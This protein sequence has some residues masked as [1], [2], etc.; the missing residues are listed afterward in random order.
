DM[1]ALRNKI[2][3]RQYKAQRATLEARMEGYTQTIERT[4]AIFRGA[5]GAY[6]DYVKQLDL[7]EADLTDAQ[8]TLNTLEARQSRG[9]ISM[10]TYKKNIAD[11]QKT[12]DRA[13]SIMNGTLL[14]LREKIR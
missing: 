11:A 10:E 4:K 8:E 2:P 5:S 12:R 1:K 6:P 13:E 3:R 7:A 14:R 9:E